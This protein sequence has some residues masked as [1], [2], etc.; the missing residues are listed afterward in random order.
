MVLYTLHLFS[1]AGGGIL[2][3]LLLGHRP[4]G[5][6]EIDAYARQV[7]L[8]R[9]V[10]GYIPKFPIWD[11]ILTFRRDNPNTAG[12]IKRLCGI[13]DKLCISGG[14][15]C[16]DVSAAGKGAGITGEKSGLWREFARVVG[17]IR[18]RYVFLENSNLLIRRGLETVLSDVTAMGYSCAWGVISAA[19]VGAPHKR[20]RF[21]AVCSLHTH[22]HKLMPTPKAHD[23]KQTVTE[24]TLKRHSLDLTNYAAVYPTPCVHGVSGGSG[25]VKKIKQM[26]ELTDEEKRSMVSGNGGK[27]N[28]D[29]VEYLMGWI[30]GWTQID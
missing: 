27:L 22:T 25:N 4:I 18:P 30:P 28:P 10:D 7:L 21:W 12:Y 8:C 26:K 16:Q 19:D 23:A 11:D 14:F 1:G 24:A 6:V 9:Q 20:Q 5:A 29:W 17:E 13:R 15:P 2:A 3:D